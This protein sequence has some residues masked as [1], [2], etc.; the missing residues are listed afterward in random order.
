MKNNF[1]IAL[2]LKNNLI[3]IDDYF[4]NLQ[5]NQLKT[6][7]FPSFLQLNDVFIK[8]NKNIMLG[9]QNVQPSKNVV[10]GEVLVSQLIKFDVKYCIVGHSERRINLNESNEQI[11]QKISLLLEHNITP[12]LCVGE[13]IKTNITKAIN[14]ID[15]Q[16]LDCLNLINIDI[17]QKIILAYEPV[18]AIGTGIACEKEH[19]LNVVDHIK[20]NYQFL[21]VLYGG[22]VNENNCTQI[23]K[24]NCIDGF[25][26]GSS[27][28]NYQKINTICNNIENL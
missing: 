8:K 12:I 16:I 24:L 2:N 4:K 25:L 19:I 18:F 21:S 26:I 13:N 11:A 27:S 5:K 23:A 17:Q 15:K 28:L 20:Q 10:T 14:F 6:I 1:I 22:S 9:S 3:D 7:I